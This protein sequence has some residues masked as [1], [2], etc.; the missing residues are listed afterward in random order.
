MIRFTNFIV[1]K[2]LNVADDS[3]LI[4]KKKIKGSAEIVE[5]VRNISMKYIY[6][7]YKITV[8]ELC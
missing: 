4:S 1:L 8:E 7:K 2:N 5:T 3:L 6:M